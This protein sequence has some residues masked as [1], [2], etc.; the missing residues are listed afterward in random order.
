MSTSTDK[1]GSKG[2][3]LLYHISPISS[4]VYIIPQST[5]AESRHIYMRQS[6]GACGMLLA[7]G[8]DSFRI[9]GPQSRIACQE[10][11]MFIEELRECDYVGCFL[12]CDNPSF[13]VSE[14]RISEERR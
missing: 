7:L 2:I 4:V 14:R 3:V 12:P 6:N 13:T 9:Q 1:L 5:S 11:S 10:L 8:N